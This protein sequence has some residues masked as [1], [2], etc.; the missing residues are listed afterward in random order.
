MKE[1]MYLSELAHITSSNRLLEAVVSQD[2]Q[3]KEHLMYDKNSLIK[4]LNRRINGLSLISKRSNFQTRL[5]V[6]EGI[7][8]SKI[9]YLIQVWGGTYDYLVNALQVTQN[10]CMRQITGFSWYTPTGVLLRKCKWMSIRQLI[11]YHSILTIHK[12]CIS[13]SPKYIFDKMHP[14]SNYETRHSVK[15]GANFKGR[16]WRAQSSLC[17]RG[18]VLYNRVPLEIIQTEGI[19]TFKRKL[20]RWIQENIPVN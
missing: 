6:A 10:R 7:V 1:K 15:Y 2:L 11:A 3:W 19:T 4:Q 12:S 17:Y 16:S 8:L 20:K 18:T 14:A 13:G 9:I 5:S